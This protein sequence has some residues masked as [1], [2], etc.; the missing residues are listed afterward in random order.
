MAY[1]TNNDAYEVI[2]QAYKEWTGEELTTSEDATLELKGI[3]DTGDKSNDIAK[4]TEQFTKALIVTLIKRFYTDTAYT[5]G[6]VDPWLVDSAQYGAILQ[7]L[8]IE[9]PDIRESSA[10]KVWTNGDDITNADKIFMPVI[11][12]KLYGSSVAYE[13]PIA[14][15]DNQWN[16]ALESM[17]KV[18]ELVA[19][20]QLVVQNKLSVHRE[21]LSNMARVELIA[22][23][24][25]AAGT[26]GQ[27]GIHKVN[28]VKEYTDAF[29]ITTG[30]TAQA[31]IKDADAL[32]W[33][34]KRFD[35]Y[36]R[37]LMLD[38]TLYNV[39]GL[40]KFVPEDR[41]VLELNSDFESVMSST[42]YS[43]TYNPEYVA[44]P[45]YRVVP[46][47]QFDEMGYNS[48]GL[49]KSMEINIQ[50]AG[51]VDVN[52]KNVV[53]LMCDKWSIRHTIIEE[54]V[55]AHRYDRNWI[56]QY[57]YQFKDRFDVD[58]QLPSIVFTIEDVAAA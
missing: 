37:R 46:Y 56:T 16:D 4:A 6:L 41:L 13:L 57:Y 22:E 47:W 52:V 10:W 30:M 7:Q 39:D 40:H 14:I 26:V 38:S 33:V 27:A 53:G 15:A 1:L 43:T 8:S 34:A 29:G 17:E 42:M 44:L 28:L 24:V 58:L 55:A 51:E 2:K 23:K 35:Y 48:N 9:V 32:R 5:S 54:K 31:F 50:T 12:A 36:K 49:P 18:T 11:H 19:H 25:H 20:I 45:N 3:I 21:A